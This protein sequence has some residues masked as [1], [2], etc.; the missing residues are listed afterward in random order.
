V[1]AIKTRSD[2]RRHAQSQACH[3]AT[4]RTIWAVM[5]WSETETTATEWF[6]VLV[7]L[8]EV[9]REEKR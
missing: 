7:L 5:N 6:H 8:G 1:P 3:N 2:P 9:R 4:T